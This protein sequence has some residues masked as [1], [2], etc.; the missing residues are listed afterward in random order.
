MSIL[1]LLSPLADLLAIVLSL[2][3]LLV[4][5]IGFFASIVFY[6][7]GRDLQQMATE[8]LTRIS[9]KS[10]I[11]QGQVGGILHKTLDAA[12][13]QNPIESRLKNIENSLTESRERL[14][15]KAREELS[16]SDPSSES[17]LEEVFN[18]EF[19]ALEKGVRDA[20]TLTERL[21]ELSGSHSVVST[22][23]TAHH[24]E[25]RILDLV[26]SSPEPLPAPEILARLASSPEN[27]IYSEDD[28]KRSLRSLQYKGLLTTA[29]DEAGTLLVSP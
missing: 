13:Q 12:L 14:L 23:T 1:Q 8:A 10:E 27:P 29:F 2:V 6:R 19:N 24:L 3:A 17:K 22:A 25:A 21:D 20:R 9:E 7:D 16:S 28:L 5:I 15:N 18:S 4:T 11:I 26:I